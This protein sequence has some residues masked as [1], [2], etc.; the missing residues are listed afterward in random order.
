M[1]I[2]TIG[3]AAGLTLAVA[4]IPIL[5][6]PAQADFASGKSAYERQDYKSALKNWRPLAMKGDARAMF[7][8]GQL[9]FQGRGGISKN[10]AGAAKWYAK[11]ADKGHPGATFRLAELYFNGYGVPQNDAK[12]AA[13][14][15]NAAQKGHVKAMVAMGNIYTEGEVLPRDE[16]KARRWYRKAVLGGSTDAMVLLSEALSNS[17]RI[18]RDYRRAY[19][20]LLVAQK[21]GHPAASFKRTELHKRVNDG[22]VLRAKQWANDYLTKGKIPPRLAYED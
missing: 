7:G 20:W 19:T 15:R 16:R 12:A 8:L 14:F 2:C 1:S 3:R 5:A 13:L 9:Y 6:S 18:P 11:A 10:Y 4:A 17:E 21:K 22:E